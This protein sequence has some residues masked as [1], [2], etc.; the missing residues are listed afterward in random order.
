MPGMFLRDVASWLRLYL[1]AKP[2]HRGVDV[3]RLAYPLQH[4][5]ACGRQ[6]RGQGFLSGAVLSN[7]VLVGGG[8]FPG[9]AKPTGLDILWSVDRLCIC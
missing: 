2:F 1:A 3:D 6:T 9:S 8:A 4:P 7:H 5:M